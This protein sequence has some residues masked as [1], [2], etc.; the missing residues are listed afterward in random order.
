MCSPLILP[1]ILAKGF[2]APLPLLSLPPPSFR[3]EAPSPAA[4]FEES[5]KVPPVVE[6]DRFIPVPFAN[7]GEGGSV[8]N[9]E[10][11]DSA[12]DKAG[13][14]LGRGDFDDEVPGV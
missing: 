1:K 10:L 5:V 11:F 3:S 7:A 14:L 9:V 12:G 2:S 8:G 4:P 13:R 6:L